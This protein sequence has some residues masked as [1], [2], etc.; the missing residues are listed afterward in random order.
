MRRADVGKPVDPQRVLAKYPEWA[1]ELREYFDGE[2]QG[3]PDKSGALSGWLRHRRF[4]R[5][6]P[7]IVSS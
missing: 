5:V 1:D 7:G 6:W 2:Q 3:S 4:N